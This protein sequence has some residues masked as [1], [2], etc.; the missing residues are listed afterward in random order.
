M[1]IVKREP[2]RITADR[3]D[4]DDAAVT[5]AANGDALLRPVTLELRTRAHHPQ[6][7]G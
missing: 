2:H 4:S 5:L 1:H 3:L 7:F 6:I